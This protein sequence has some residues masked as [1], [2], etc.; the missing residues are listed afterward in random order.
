MI[1][2]FELEITIKKKNH[3]DGKKHNGI[4]LYSTKNPVKRYDKEIRRTCNAY[5]TLIAKLLNYIG[6]SIMVPIK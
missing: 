2:F 3:A 4:S 5:Q 6:S 1:S